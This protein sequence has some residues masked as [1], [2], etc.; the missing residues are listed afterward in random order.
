MQTNKNYEKAYLLLLMRE[1]AIR[2]ARESFWHF[3]KLLH[4]YKEEWHHLKTFSYTLQMFYEGKLINPITNKAYRKLMVN[5][6]PRHYKTRT[7]MLFSCWVFGKNANEKII[8][9][10]Y[11]DDLATDFSKYTRDEIAREK[12]FDYEI[13]YSDIF[14][15]TRIKKGDASYKKWALEGKHFSYKGSGIGGSITGKGCTIGIIDDQVKNYAEATNETLLEKNWNWYTGTFLSRFE[16]GACQIICMT[17][18]SDKDI[19][20]KILDNEDEKDSW[21]VLKYKAYDEKKD[22]VLCPDMLSKESYFE[23]KRTINEDIFYANYQQETI[24]KKGRLYKNLKTYKRNEL[25]KDNNGN[26]IADRFFSYIDTA[27]QGDDYLCCVLGIEYEKQMYIT[28]I[29]YTQEA[30]E[31]TEEETAKRIIN[32]NIK[33]AVVESNNGG[34]AFA[35]NISRILQ[36]KYKRKDISVKWLHQSENKKSRILT[37]SSSI[38]NN[39]FFPF[40]W[41][42]KYPLFYESVTKYM[43]KANNKHDDA[44]DTLTGCIEYMNGLLDKKLNTILSNIDFSAFEVGII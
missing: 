1:K 12:T 16:E 3:C 27:D 23:K 25:P 15:G 37:N 4:G 2:K 30:Q 19:C 36:E 13:T 6:P 21:Y 29:Y 41:K 38:E 40:N 44:P 18:W 17:R 7:L 43:R 24:D 22:E 5:M 11:S 10:A 31:V 14:P 32:N 34:R 35:R 39:I 9:T 20:G 28:D 8:A 26:I 33:V 42:N